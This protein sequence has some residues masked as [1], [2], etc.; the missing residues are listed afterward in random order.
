MTGWGWVVRGTQASR[1]GLNCD[2]P[3]ALEGGW[4]DELAATK[5]AERFIPQKARDGAAVLSARADPFAG[6]KGEER[7]RPAPF[8]MTVGGVVRGTQASRPGLNCD[9]PPALEGGWRDELAA[10]KGWGRLMHIFPQT[11]HLLAQPRRL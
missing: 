5:E 7:R 6:A 2:A 8:G 11:C 1:P 9:A 10:T 4:R 3:P